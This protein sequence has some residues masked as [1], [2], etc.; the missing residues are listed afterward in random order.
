MLF[1]E[2]GCRGGG[3]T[4]SIAQS[5]S[6]GFLVFVRW[7]A[8]LHANI[9]SH[10]VPW[11]RVFGWRYYYVYTY[12]YIYG[13]YPGAY[14]LFKIICLRFAAL[15]ELNPSASSGRRYKFETPCRATFL[16]A[17]PSC[18]D[19]HT[20]EH[21]YIY[22]SIVYISPSLFSLLSSLFSLLSSLFSL[23]SSVSFRSQSFLSCTPLV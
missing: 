6:Y 23:L 20:Q 16:L 21:V 2:L 1:L 17:G 3:I 13:A 10:C 19:V 8:E 14:P 11:T 22:V 15:C 5:V 12:I 18:S 7:A 9:A 4:M